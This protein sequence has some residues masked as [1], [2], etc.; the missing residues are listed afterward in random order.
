MA[1]GKNKSVIRKHDAINNNHPHGFI[2]NN[3]KVIKPA[4]IPLTKTSFKLDKSKPCISCDPERLVA[5]GIQFKYLDTDFP[6]V[7][8]CNSCSVKAS[9]NLSKIIEDEYGG[10]ENLDEASEVVAIQEAVAAEADKKK[11]K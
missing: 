8:L 7:S 11:A 6:V 1:T 9:R 4:T 2:G 10:I 3:N 5:T